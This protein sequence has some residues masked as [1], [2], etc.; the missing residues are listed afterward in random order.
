V[1]GELKRVENNPNWKTL[2]GEAG[3][4]LSSISNKHPGEAFIKSLLV[5]YSYLNTPVVSQ[6]G[7]YTGHCIRHK[8]A[9]DNFDHGAYLFYTYQ[10]KAKRNGDYYEPAL[11]VRNVRSR[12]IKLH[13]AQNEKVMLKKWK[14]IAAH[15]VIEDPVSQSNVVP[16]LRYRPRHS[17]QHV[18]FCYSKQRRIIKIGITDNLE[19]RL[20]EIR[21]EY[22][23][24]DAEYIYVEHFAGKELEKDLHIQFDSL[25]IKNNPILKTEWFEYNPVIGET[26]ASL[27]NYSYVIKRD[28]IDYD[29]LEDVFTS[30]RA[31][32]VD[33]EMVW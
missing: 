25:N 31:G 29:F 33:G 19:R 7:P 3:E 24:Y 12:F 14:K 26:I 21:S 8:I 11:E 6:K 32:W 17:N 5:H 23:V 1:Q 22:K 20:K 9:K 18:Y 15:L 30:E 2:L 27:A 28:E 4:V 10:F 16:K 13:A